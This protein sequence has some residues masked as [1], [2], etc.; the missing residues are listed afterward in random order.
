MLKIAMDGDDLS[1]GQNRLSNVDPTQ[2]G[3][4]GGG[5]EEE[6]CCIM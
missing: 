2:Q 1:R 3:G 6:H 5:G 4:T